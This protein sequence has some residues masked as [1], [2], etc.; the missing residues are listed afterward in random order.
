MTAT[1]L[2][3]APS[4]RV[5]VDCVGH[6]MHN[7]LGDDIG[8]WSLTVRKVRRVRLDNHP[9]ADTATGCHLFHRNHL[10]EAVPS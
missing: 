6:T 1:T 5:R 9:Y 3:A 2:T 4:R 7:R 8:P 10:V